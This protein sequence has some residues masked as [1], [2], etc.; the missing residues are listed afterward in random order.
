MNRD[1][2]DKLFSSK[3]KRQKKRKEEEGQGP[4]TRSTEPDKAS[5]MKETVV[6]HHADIMGKHCEQ[7]LPFNAYVR[8][9]GQKAPCY[10]PGR[11]G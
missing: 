6:T 4:H 9:P 11:V 2:H 5:K 3:R 1:R 10:F 8:V 7:R